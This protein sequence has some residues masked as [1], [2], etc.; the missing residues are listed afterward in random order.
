M[1]RNWLVSLGLLALWDCEIYSDMQGGW[2]QKS[3]RN[4]GDPSDDLHGVRIVLR[5]AS[6]A[7]VRCS[8]HPAPND[9][10][11]GVV[12]NTARPRREE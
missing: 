3:P 5:C 2:K 7:A 8:A 11:A 10:T 4:Q 12:V 6:V 9:R 1:F